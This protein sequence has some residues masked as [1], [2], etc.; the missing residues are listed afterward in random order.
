M[1]LLHKTNIWVA[2]SHW[3][4]NLLVLSPL[5]WTAFFVAGERLRTVL[6][7]KPG[8]PQGLCIC[9]SGKTVGPSVWPSKVCA[10]ILLWD[11]LSR[12]CNLTCL[13][14]T[15]SGVFQVFLTPLFHSNLT[16]AYSICSTGVYGS[17]NMCRVLILGSRSWSDLPYG[18]A[19]FGTAFI[20]QPPQAWGDPRVLS[21]SQ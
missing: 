16:V 11:I 10:I 18:S 19:S 17:N 1:W 5:L 8:L 6:G 21:V 14:Q 13:S 15:V 9:M 4:L 7:N 12:V 20:P 2:Y 3:N